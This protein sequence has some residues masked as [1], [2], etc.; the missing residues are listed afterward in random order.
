VEIE[1]KL[2][3]EP[4]DQRRVARLD[5]VR[6][7]TAGRPH[8]QRL[9][10]VYFDTPGL[11]LAADRVALRVREHPGRS[12]STWTQTLKDAGTATGGLHERDEIEW[13]LAGPALDLALIDASPFAERFR[14]PKL[15]EALKPAFSTDFQRSARILRFADGTTVEMAMDVGEVR[16]GRRTD[17]IA[18]IE[19]E[20]KSGDPARLFDLA[21]AIV[22]AVPARVGHESKAARGYRLARGVRMAPAQ[23]SR[24]VAL[25]RGTPA[26][27]A[28]R[29]IMGACL[30]QM[31]ANEAGARIGRQP[32]YLHQFRVGMRRLRSCLSLVAGAGGRDAVAPLAEDLRWLGTAM[33]PARDWDV[34]MTQTLPPLAGMFGASDGVDALRRTGA[35]LRTTHHRAVREALGS[36]RYQRMLLRFGRVLAHEE[37]ASLRGES[38]APAAVTAPDKP[39]PMNDDGAD[40]APVAPVVHPFDQPIERFAAGILQR[41]HRKVRKRGAGVPDAPSEARHEVRI[42]AKKLRYA[43][44]FFAPL[45]AKKRTAKYVR[46]LTGIQDILG[47]LNDAAVTDRLLAEAHAKASID[48]E[49]TG[50]VR[51][52]FGAVAMHELARF[53][54]AWESF[55]SQKAFW[56]D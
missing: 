35:R 44:E 27:A 15:R 7:L 1:L 24:P 28:L 8:S 38:P 37:I 39:A 46:A 50:L 9:N 43:A 2:L 42:A 10:N 33:N 52:W 32:E 19:L 36:L 45:Y 6:R 29:R 51:G 40:A 5:L 48:A 47:A 49:V 41:R 20:L 14:R 13:R 34:F 21:D 25:E 55:E 18:E 53:R 56:R 54:D 30:A 4:A 31:Q 22:A 23:K 26:S 17:A 11:D 3:V 16:A 12:G